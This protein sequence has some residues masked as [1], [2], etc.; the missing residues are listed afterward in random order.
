M[1]PAH[2]APFSQSKLPT[3]PA[4]SHTWSNGKCAQLLVETAGFS[5][6]TP[7]A[8]A[9]NGNVVAAVSTNMHVNVHVL[10]LQ[11]HLHTQPSHTRTQ[12]CVNMMQPAA[13]MHC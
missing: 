2:S 4:I 10:D 7:W 1:L 9:Y 8:C 3:L 6:A 5:A 12:L 11:Q 13:G